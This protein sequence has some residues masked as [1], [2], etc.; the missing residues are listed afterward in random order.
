LNA[1]NVVVTDPLTPHYGTFVLNA[2]KL[3]CLI[4]N[5]G[6]GEILIPAASDADSMF[7]DLLEAEVMKANHFYSGNC[8]VL[9]S[10]ERVP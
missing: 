10:N 7:L 5:V 2:A 6:D 3:K 9:L 8:F 1:P 4:G